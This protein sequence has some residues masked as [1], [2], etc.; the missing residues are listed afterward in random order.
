VCVLIVEL[1]SLYHTQEFLPYNYYKSLTN[2]FFE[3]AR[4][5]CLHRENRKLSRQ[6]LNRFIITITFYNAFVTI[7]KTEIKKMIHS[8]CKISNLQS[9]KLGIQRAS[10]FIYYTF[11]ADINLKIISI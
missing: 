3:K 5:F 7:K 11:F 4:V 10:N 2:N 9:S 8:F 1:E 6:D